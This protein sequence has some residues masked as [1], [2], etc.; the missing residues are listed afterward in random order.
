VKIEKISNDKQKL[1]IISLIVSDKFSEKIMPILEENRDLIYQTFTD[2]YKIVLNWIFEYYK[3][4]N[5]APHNHI[6]DI[7]NSKKQS[8]DEEK[9]ELIEKFLQHLSNKYERDEKYNEDYVIDESLKYLR[10]VN[11]NILQKKINESKS[12]NNIDEAENHIL[13]YNRLEKQTEI[14]QETFIFSD[15]DKAAEVCEYSLNENEGDRL[16]KLS[17]DLGHKLE[18]IYR[19]DFFSIVGPAK[20]GK[21]YYLREIAILAATIYN[22]NVILFNL[23]MSHKKYS[24]ILYQNIANET[25]FTNDKDKKE[26][27]IPYFEY[28]ETR[29]KN[30][31]KY[32]TLKKTGLSGKKIKS[33]LKRK[34]VS[35]KGELIIRSFPSK[36]LTYQKIYQVLDDYVL[37]GFVPDLILFDFLDNIKILNKDEHRHKID[38]IWNTGRRLAQEKHLAVGTVSHTT[39][40]GFKNDLDQ[41]DVNEDY[42]K[43]NHVTHMIGL[44]QTPEEKNQ[45]ITRINI[46]HNRDEDFNPKQFFVALEC[47]DIGR[48]L[49]DNLDLR[50]VDYKMKK[51][52]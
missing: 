43:E 51:G 46:L 2:F 40:K 16:F 11:L 17:G 13:T 42:R 30:E 23:E 52:E 10:E 6:Q 9:I 32:E 7:F 37:H 31:I 19:E 41:G 28:N 47:R 39:R 22:L 8:L 5:K 4:Y 34:K 25:K 3:K 50:K 44:N 45:Q 29:K 1:I 12:D 49:L 27:R 15:L 38:T 18:W 36:T 14:K 33:I 48:V 21:S 26:I 35:G 24:R 20:R